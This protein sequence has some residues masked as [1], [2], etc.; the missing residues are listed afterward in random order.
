MVDLI[1]H[2]IESE[3]FASINTYQNAVK[4]TIQH[5]EE[6]IQ[7]TITKYETAFD[8]TVELLSPRSRVT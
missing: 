8:A 4:D 7:S 6:A 5:Y 1:G 2:M 3:S